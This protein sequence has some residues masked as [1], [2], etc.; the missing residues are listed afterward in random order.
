MKCA[1]GRPHTAGRPTPRSD[2]EAGP[3]LLPP[4]EN[5]IDQ[6]FKRPSL[7]AVVGAAVV[8]ADKISISPSARPYPERRPL[9]AVRISRVGLTQISH[10]DRLGR[11]AVSPQATQARPVEQQSRY[12]FCVAC[13]PSQASRAVLFADDDATA[14]A[15]DVLPADVLPADVP[16]AIVNDDD[17]DG[18]VDV[19]ARTPSPPA[20]LIDKGTTY[21]PFPASL[22]GSANDGELVTTVRDVNGDCHYFLMTEETSHQW[23]EQLST[24][25]NDA[26]ANCRL[27]FD[28]KSLE[29]VVTKAVKS[30][31]DLVA[32]YTPFQPKI[33]KPV[34]TPAA[35]PTKKYACTRCQI[36]S[37]SN[38]QNLLAHQTYYCKPTNADGDRST[39]DATP[40]RTASAAAA[41][42]KSPVSVAGGGGMSAA[43]RP[44]PSLGPRLPLTPAMRPMVPNS[45]G[46][47]SGAQ[48]CQPPP[49]AILLPVA[50][51]LR[52]DAQVMQVIGLPQVVIP[53]AIPKPSSGA[54]APL[55]LMLEFSLI[56][57]VELPQMTIPVNSTDLNSPFFL[58][59]AIRSN[60]IAASSRQ[61]PQ[62]FS[63][64]T[65][66]ARSSASPLQTATKN[67]AALGADGSKPLDLSKRRPSSRCS[68]L[69]KT[70]TPEI[71]LPP[72]T[73]P[74]DDGDN[75]P[76][77]C[78]CGIS[79]SNMNTL[80]G[81][82]KFYCKIA[83]PLEEAAVKQETPASV[84]PVIANNK[85]K[86]PLKC[87]YCNYIGQNTTQLSQHLRTIHSAI[88]GFL[89]Q[90]CGY[91]G[92]SVRGMKSHMRSHA[93][94]TGSHNVDELILGY[95]T[96]LTVEAPSKG[97]D[98]GS[99]VDK[100]NGDVS[101]PIDEPS[102][103]RSRHDSPDHITEHH[104]SSVV[105]Q[106][107]QVTFTVMT[108]YDRHSCVKVRP[109]GRRHLGA[110]GGFANVDVDGY[111]YV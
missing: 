51:N 68:S 26:E 21:G 94:L 98:G 11:V 58:P 99:G 16:P 107:C 96:T 34:D 83:V 40:P 55:P 103:K 18:V 49:N 53:V 10:A 91:K 81:H 4:N 32:S 75:K 19:I 60:S 78:N 108:D 62:H 89:C 38:R 35:A 30:I 82:K 59:V 65:Q 20:A 27:L 100:R 25:K 73:R 43:V 47:P 79:F 7:I 8:R 17:E 29:V 3:G 77:V 52:T 93:E 90:L 69:A 15:V 70:S 109:H 85:S 9:V 5:R 14:A 97:S 74:P 80:N 56:A 86:P 6:D 106:Q 72:T 2:K 64:P 104:S 76:F 92:Y 87:Q 110:G 1:G 23:L 28:G 39:E 71:R 88:Q 95:V 37:F 111:A 102:S 12:V 48:A 84:S 36:A 41:S 101:S 57:G 24:V 54:F 61:L 46:A 33:E 67:S 66:T 42:T 22:A 45:V 50:Y 63:S 44:L 105:C 13:V 31:C